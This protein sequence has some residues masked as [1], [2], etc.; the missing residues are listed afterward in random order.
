MV[1]C[2]LFKV[3]LLA[4]FCEGEDL[5][6][7]NWVMDESLSYIEYLATISD[8]SVLPTTVGLSIEMSL[9]YLKTIVTP[10]S[11]LKYL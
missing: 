4:T 1:S 2:P 10:I 11:T 3:L 8:L 5:K 6:N 7:I 9:P